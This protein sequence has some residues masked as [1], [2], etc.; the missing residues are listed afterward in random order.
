MVESKEV[1]ESEVAERVKTEELIE[2]YEEAQE[3][4]LYI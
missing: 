3:V 2:E 4:Q 1:Q